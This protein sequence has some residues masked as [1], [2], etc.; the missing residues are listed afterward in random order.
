MFTFFTNPLLCLKQD[1][2][3][4][5]LRGE[6]KV[7]KIVPSQSGL[8]NRFLILISHYTRSAFFLLLNL[9]LLL[10][11]PKQTILSK[12]EFCVGSEVHFIWYTLTFDNQAYFD[13]VMKT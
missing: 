12:K 6:R 4:I 2:F 8:K 3:K 9:Y 1:D 13:Q 5:T 10:Y 11:F 7:V